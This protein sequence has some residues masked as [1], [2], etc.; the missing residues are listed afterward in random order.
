[1]S[2]TIQSP[3]HIH[4]NDSA[5]FLLSAIKRR[6]DFF[7]EKKIQKR[8]RKSGIRNLRFLKN[9]GFVKANYVYEDFKRVE[10]FHITKQGEQFIKEDRKRFF[11]AALI[12]I[13][14]T[15]LT[16]IFTAL[17]SKFFS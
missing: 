17:W 3:N 10:A 6:P 8:F 13:V 14:F 9:I 12:F 15:L 7:T 2:P 16:S 5:Q 11:S 4:L 1:M